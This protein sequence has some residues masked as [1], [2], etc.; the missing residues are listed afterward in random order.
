MLTLLNARTGRV[1]ASAVEVA[2]TRTERRRGLLGRRSLDVS[3]ALMLSPCVAVHTA[4]MHF[5]IDVVFVDEDGTVVRI[6]ETLRPWRMA[7]CRRARTVIECAGG[8][9][10]RRDV[11]VG[12]R[13]C[14]AAAHVA[15]A[16]AS[17]GPVQ[18]LAT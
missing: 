17:G 2:T 3:A 5:A 1:V 6:V 10:R 9:V 12:D 4:F 8:T 14:F 11:L 16:S 7:A 18:A 13:L 15:A